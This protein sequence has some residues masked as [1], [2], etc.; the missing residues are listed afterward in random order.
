MKLI[1]ILILFFTLPGCSQQTKLDKL[2]LQL[3]SSDFGDVYEAKDSIV[4]YGRDGIPR[5]IKLLRDT[6]FVKLK[7]TADLI[8]PGAEEFYGHGWIVHYDIDWISERAA[9]LL[10]EI[11]FQDFGYRDLSIN[12]DSLMKLHLQDYQSYLQTGTIK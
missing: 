5:L 10:E 4:N 12:E 11:T 7:N 9:W 6:S 3:R 1:V 8:Y 2:I